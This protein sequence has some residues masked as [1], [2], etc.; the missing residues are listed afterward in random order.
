MRIYLTGFMSSGKSSLGRQ[1]AKKTGLLFTDLDNIIVQAENG[2]SIPKIFEQKGEDYF[3]Q[4]E[5]NCLHQ[6]FLFDNTI[7]ACGGGTPCYFDNLI[8]LKKHGTLVYLQYSP[9]LLYKRL[10]N[11]RNK[12]KRPLLQN[13]RDEELFLN[14]EQLLNKR[15]TFYEQAHIIVPCEE[16]RISQIDSYILERLQRLYPELNKAIYNMNPNINYTKLS[17]TISKA[18]RHNPDK[19]GITLDKEGWTPTTPLLHSLQK[20]WPEL[21]ENDL[22]LTIELGLK[23]SNPKK[24][25]EIKEGKI[26]ALYGHSIP[27][28]IVKPSVEPPEILY[29]GTAN[30]SIPYIQEEGLKS[31]NRQYVHLSEDI[32]TAIMVGKRRDKNPVVFQVK[33]KKAYQ[34]GILFYKEQNKVWLSEPVPPEY[35][36]F[37]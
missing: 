37:K 29:H 9:A 24:R 23:G 17:K 1:L 12:N 26:R 7:I 21:K 11:Q 36:V 33:A 3:R 14:I 4:K 28:K 10:Q 27:Q 6:T 18:L 34:S 13:I 22:Y 16:L 5:K 35:I 2:L 31:M 32:D 25:F 19:F 15:K 30:K 20:T 8:Q